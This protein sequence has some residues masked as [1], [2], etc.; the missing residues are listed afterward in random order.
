MQS[1]GKKEVEVK[2][3]ATKEGAAIKATEWENMNL[4]WKWTGKWRVTWPEVTSVLEMEHKFQP[5]KSE[6]MA[7][8]ESQKNARALYQSLSTG[9]SKNIE[10]GP[11]IGDEDAQRHADAWL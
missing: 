7:H 11:T 1:S 10:V 5:T 9:R 3:V 6:Q 4:G 8:Y 2:Y